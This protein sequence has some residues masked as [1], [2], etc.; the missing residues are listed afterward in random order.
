MKI[1][2]EFQYFRSCP[3]YIKMLT[4]LQKAMNGLED[5]I[6]FKKIVVENEETARKVGFR[7]SPTI[8]IAGKDLEN[9]PVPTKP[10]MACRFYSNSIPSSEFIRKIIFEKIKKK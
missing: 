3:H 1:S 4:N 6:Q 10:A 9:L 7:G 8:I 2:I 5:K